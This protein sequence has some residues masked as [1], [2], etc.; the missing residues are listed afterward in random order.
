MSSLVSLE[1]KRPTLLTIS[2]HRRS[3]STP[4]RIPSCKY[5][6]P[7]NH[8]ERSHKTATRGLMG[9]RRRGGESKENLVEGGAGGEGVEV[10]RLVEEG[11]EREVGVLLLRR[12]GGVEAHLHLHL[13]ADFLHLDHSQSP[14]AREGRDRRLKPYRSSAARRKGSDAEEGRKGNWKRREGRRRPDLLTG[15]RGSA[16]GARWAVDDRS[17]GRNRC[18]PRTD[19]R[20]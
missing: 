17:N 16:G 13:V 11:G 8:S 2:S 3:R 6:K 12:R 5:P 4:L 18:V 1:E 7:S 19:G 10:G 9:M 15:R 20:Q 14:S